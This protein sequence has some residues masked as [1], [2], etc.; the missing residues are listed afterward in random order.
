[1]T[2]REPTTRIIKPAEY[3]AMPS[4]V[5][6]DWKKLLTGK[7]LT[8]KDVAYLEVEE[9]GT[10]SAVIVERKQSLVSNK[11]NPRSIRLGKEPP[12]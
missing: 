12:A 2:E 10:A 8:E 7:G 1:M 5:R 3:Q 6:R 4:K 11:V 9:D